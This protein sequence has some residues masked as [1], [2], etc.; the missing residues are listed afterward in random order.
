MTDGGTVHCAQHSPILRS[1]RESPR[2]MLCE[3]RLESCAY[4]VYQTMD[5]RLFPR[6]MD[7]VGKITARS[8]FPRSLLYFLSPHFP[9]LTTTTFQSPFHTPHKPSSPFTSFTPFAIAAFHHESRFR[10]RRPHSPGHL[11]RDALR[12]SFYGSFHPRSRF[13][14]AIFLT[15]SP[16]GLP[17]MSQEW[18]RTCVLDGTS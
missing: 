9:P 18:P 14:H 3:P 2:S 7:L 11:V 16:I 10:L 12:L 5:C 4:K 8:T 13:I 15:F 1:G 6:S 17:G